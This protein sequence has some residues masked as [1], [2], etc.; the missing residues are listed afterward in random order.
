MHI[1]HHR[2]VSETLPAAIQYLVD[3]GRKENSRNGP[4]LVAPTPVMTIYD[5]PGEKVVFNKIRDGNPF[6]H[7]MEALW[8]LNGDD[9][10][11]FL[12]HYISDFGNR[13]GDDGTIMGAYGYR[14]R[15]NFGIDQIEEIIKKF[16]VN[17]LDRQTVLTMWDPHCI[18][19]D[20]LMSNVRDR[21]CNTHIYFRINNGELDMTTMARSHDALFGATGANAVHF[22]FLQ[23]Y[24]A[25]MLGV[26]LGKFYQ[27]SNNWHVY[28]DV[29]DKLA[30]KVTEPVFTWETVLADERYRHNIS[31]VKPLVTNPKS[32]DKELKH[33]IRLVRELQLGSN[34]LVE[35]HNFDNTFLSKVMWTAAYIH[36]VYKKAGAK[37]AYDYTWG[38]KS[39]DWQVA[40]REWLERRIK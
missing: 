20:D 36:S 4:V 18:H 1:L 19:A 30:A 16:K 39:P 7:L 40:C 13:Y 10:A 3:Y 2:N 26:K 21:P 12:N 29:L 23:E 6:F 37:I 33:I 15:G 28:Q 32:F 22:A 27:F 11:E 34:H 38:I 31:S 35:L 14:W 24:V 17:P 25:G 5:R 9:D 8:M